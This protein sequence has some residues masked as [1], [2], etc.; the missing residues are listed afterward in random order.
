MKIKILLIFIL[1]YQVVVSQKI[2]GTVSNKN[3]IPVENANVSIWNSNNKEILFGYVYTNENGFFSID[4]KP[5]IKNAYLT[6]SCIDFASISQTISITEQNQKID[7][8]LENKEIEL[9]E[10]IVKDDKAV[11]VKNDTT[12]Y[13]PKKFLNGS[14]NK[15]EDLIKKLPGMTVNS[16]TGEIKFKGKAI[17]TVKLENDNL[18]GGNYS[19]GTKN[20]S[21]EMVEQVQAIENYSE[22]PLLKGIEDSDN[23]AINLK[24]KKQKADY[25][26]T[27][28]ISNGASD[29][30]LF[31]DEVNL[32][33]I[34]KN[35]KSFGITS[36]NNFGGGT[37]DINSFSQGFNSSDVPE[38]EFYATK[39]ISE[40]VASSSL[41]SNRTT[42]NDTFLANY[43]F[44]YKLTP[45]IS[46]K[47]NLVNFY[48]QTKSFEIYSNQFFLNN[49][50]LKTSQENLINKKTN[51]FKADLKLSYNL[52]KS[53]LLVTSASFSNQL[54]NS[55]L[56]SIQNN[57]NLYLNNLRND[58]LFYKLKTNYTWRINN[59]NALQLYSEYSKNKIPQLLTISPNNNFISGDFF[60]DSEQN[61]QFSRQIYSNSCTY[62]QNK[63]NLK[64]SF[65]LG[66]FKENSLLNSKLIENSTTVN[67]F[68]NNLNY[69]KTNLFLEYFTSFDLFKIKIQP[70][71]SSNWVNQNLKNY[72]VNDLNKSEVVNNFSIQFNFKYNKNGNV[73]LAL[74]T[75]SKTPEEEFLFSNNVLENNNSYKNNIPSLDIVKNQNIT[76]GY[77]YYNLIKQIG[78]DFNLNYQNKQN[79]F[80]SN[81]IINP[82]FVT[83]TYFQSPTNIES[84]TIGLA[85]EK[86]I[87]FLSLYFKQTSSYSINNYKNAIDNFVIRNN[88]SKNLNVSSLIFS[89]FNFLIN[90]DNKFSYN[91]SDFTSNNQFVNQ[92]ISLNNTFKILIKPEGSFTY[93]LIQDYFVTNTK[94]KT[95]FN[96]IDFDIKYKSQKIKCISINFTAKNLLNIKTFTETNNSDFSIT[97]YSTNLLPRYFLFTT[98]LNF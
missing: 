14:E 1:T 11:R 33:G 51:G 69:K 82:N 41:P 80:L 34:S 73:L 70:Y 77:K 53:S 95:N 75:I 31:N 76:L 96:F 8:V 79:T 49:S 67:G 27:S 3:N 84:K 72:L 44:I 63:K 26:G 62:L 55:N 30:I 87:N 66:F 32:L 56:S 9:E 42:F 18:F 88:V 78:F 89:T 60:K 98:S 71:L 85:F 43:N 68:E 10:V 40:P 38:A 28:S 93:S 52:N 48:D 36:Y 21:V 83:T 81:F 86:Q 57:S 16:K 12:F 74:S 2:T 58:N 45:K 22:N 15:V 65:V 20:I 90:F 29:K 13:D 59:K 54:L 97:F 50:N 4:I 5:E 39:L 25:S 23:I 35:I 47:N 91:L 24:L 64:Q 92:R 61:S 37:M 17:E 7:F 46:I 94:T 6:V 19:I